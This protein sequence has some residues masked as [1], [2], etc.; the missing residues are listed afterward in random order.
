MPPQ[1]T[2][3][4]S[5]P[6]QLTIDQKAMAAAKPY[7]EQRKLN[8]RAKISII[9]VA[10]GAGVDQGYLGLALRVIEFCPEHVAAVEQGSR[11]LVELDALANSRTPARLSDPSGAPVVFS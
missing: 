10:R 6:P 4:V 9:D 5:E 7:A 8:P 11:T 1:D 3:P 2:D